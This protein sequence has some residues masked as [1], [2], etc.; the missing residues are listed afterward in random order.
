[1]A[2]KLTPNYVARKSTILSIKIP[3]IIMFIIFV[4][5]LVLDLAFIM[6]KVEGDV[7][8]MV[9]GIGAGVLGLAIFVVVFIQVWFILDA[10]VHVYEFYDDRIVEKEGLLRINERQ[11][12]FAGVYSVNVT[13]GIWGRIFNF[14]DISVDCPGYWDIG[15]DH[16][17]HGD[18]RRRGDFRG[19]EGVHDPHAL[20]SYLKSKIT[21]K[22]ININALM[23]ENSGF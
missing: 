20:K 13:Q 1:M 15:S 8:P 19:I 11:S 21:S 23:V 2:G 16:I 3:L 12:V 18:K 4:A 6:P 14:G 7:L 22:G 10:R 5:L 17:V 9:C